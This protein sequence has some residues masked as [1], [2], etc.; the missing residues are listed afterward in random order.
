V[1]NHY[2]LGYGDLHSAQRFLLFSRLDRFI[3]D[4]N[5]QHASFLE[6]ADYRVCRLLPFLK[7]FGG[8]VV[9]S[10]KK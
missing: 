1:D 4:P 7:S 8:I 6:K 5:G 3:R 2:R 9:V 10:L